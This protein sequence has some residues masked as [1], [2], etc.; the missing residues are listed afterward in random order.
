MEPSR[1]NFTVQSRG[2][3]TLAAAAL[4]RLSPRERESWF[5]VKVSQSVHVLG[6][7]GG[8]GRRSSSSSSCLLASCML[9]LVSNSKVRTMCTRQNPAGF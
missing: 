9:I 4:V 1:F 3:P 7:S 2:V 6:G 8:G 5:I